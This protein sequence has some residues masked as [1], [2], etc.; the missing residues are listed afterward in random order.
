MTARLLAAVGGAGR[1]AGVAAAADLL[2]PVVLHGQGHEG[3]L[4]DT[5]LELELH[6][7]LARGHISL[8]VFWFVFCSVKRTN[9]AISFFFSVVCGNKVDSSLSLLRVV[10]SRSPHESER[11]R[12]C[13][14]SSS[15]FAS[16][17]FHCE[18]SHAKIKTSLTHV[19]NITDK[20]LQRG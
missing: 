9:C 19:C 5:T 8:V 16:S 18:P 4:H 2:L 12:L 10:H 3:G 20:K 11:I 15:F 13:V 17:L 14:V 7:A 1:E 6:A